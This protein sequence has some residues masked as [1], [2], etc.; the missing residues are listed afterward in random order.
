MSRADRRLIQLGLAAEGFDPGPADG[1][2]GRG[3]RGAIRRWQAS[4]SEE[5]TGHLH[6]ESA[7]LLLASGKHQ[8]A[9]NKAAD[10]AAFE[11]AKSLGTVE[12]LEAYLHA[13]VSGHHAEEVR[14]LLAR[15][16]RTTATTAEISSAHERSMKDAKETL[17]KAPQVLPVAQGELRPYALAA[18]A[19]VQMKVGHTAAAERAFSDALAAAR[20]KDDLGNRARTI[21]FIARAQLEAGSVEGAKRTFSEALT[22]A[23]AVDDP[24]DR[25]RAITFIAETQLE[26]ESTAAAAERTFSEALTAAK[27][28]DDPED[29]ARAITFI[30]EAQMEAESTA[31]AA[32]RTFSEALTAA[33]AVDDPEDRARAITF[34]AEAQMEA[35]N[36]AAAAERTF[37]E[38]LTAAKAV[39]DPED[40]ARAITFIAEAQMEAENT[41]AGR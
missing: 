34:I 24:E 10:D 7:K 40:R 21:G 36:T 11:R 1:L 30:A 14:R 12:S 32:E 17:I 22:T 9:Q 4:H 2:F 18:I 19:R 28:V 35:E 6:A 37:S 16:R 25:A 20:A 23:K 29:R 13:Y 8:E 41:A 27:G 5:S 31:A 39:D 26:A 3:T 15:V 33:K 38:A